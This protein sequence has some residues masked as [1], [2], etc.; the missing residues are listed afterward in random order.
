M[1]Q[2]DTLSNI[3]QTWLEAYTVSHHMNTNVT[4]FKIEYVNKVFVRHHWSSFLKHQML[5]HDLECFKKKIQTGLKVNK[6]WNVPLIRNKCLI[7]GRSYIYINRVTVSLF[8]T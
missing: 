4:Q 1:Q 2:P 8:G 6:K 5:W 3:K 7:C